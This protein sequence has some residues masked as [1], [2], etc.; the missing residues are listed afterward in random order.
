VVLIDVH[1]ES[2]A[3]RGL[4]SHQAEHKGFEHLVLIELRWKVLDEKSVENEE[5]KTS[6]SPPSRL[7]D[8][9]INLKR[10]TQDR[11]L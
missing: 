6:R 10:T 2:Q 7:K 5:R 3:H 1:G 11:R 4:D 8:E 9:Q